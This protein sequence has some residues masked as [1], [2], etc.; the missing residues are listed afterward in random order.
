M[1]YGYHNTHAQRMTCMTS[2][3]AAI[4]HQKMEDGVGVPPK[5]STVPVGT[6]TYNPIDTAGKSIPDQK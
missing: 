2:P 4:V 5:Y 3:E 1:E 6:R